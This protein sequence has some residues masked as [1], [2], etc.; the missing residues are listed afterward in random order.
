MKVLMIGSNLKVP[1][2]ITRVIK[3]YIEAGIQEKV[4]FEY[5]ATYYGKGNFLNLVYFIVKYIKL[6]VI[7]SLPNSGNYDIAHIHMSYKGSFI[8]KKYI[9]KLL[10][11]KKIPVVLH[12][13]GSQFKDYYRNSDVNQRRIIT[14]TLD[15]ASVII[16]LGESWEEFYKSISK[17]KV[18]SVDNA[19]FPKN[20][21]ENTSNK[22][23]ITCM[24]VISKRKGTFDLV[25]VAAKLK[26]KIDEKYKF[27][28]AGNGEIG[29]IN[30]KIRDYGLDDMFIIPGWISKQSKI[31]EIY[32]KS[33][34][35]ILPSYNEGMPMSI[36]E[37]MSFGLPIISTNVGSISS[38]VKP[39][40]GY[41]VEPGDIDKMANLIVEVI[42]DENKR[43][44]M[45]ESNLNKIHE[46]YNVNKSL[47]II[48]EI[49]S[50]V[51]NEIK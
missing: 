36:L 11:M 15:K 31:D 2:G 43:N 30:K 7:L 12:M 32:E 51:I 29:E 44:I 39:D 14:K 45:K 40:N 50:K 37:A 5:F 19:V 1:G 25:D 46:H 41:I 33:I 26:G 24:G 21:K 13:H 8:R 20:M 4:D 48:I 49:Y 23:Y 34:I 22:E 18:I 27:L 3:N 28:L 6:F 17:T 38:V 47:E 10:T 35:Y 16:A 42:N 9:I